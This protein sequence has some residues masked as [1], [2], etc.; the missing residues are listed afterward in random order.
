M[1]RIS[2]FVHCE[3]VPQPRAKVSTRGGFARAYV[4]AKHPINAY[5]QAIREAFQADKLSGPLGCSLLFKF[6][7]PKSHTKKQRQCGWHTGNSDIDNLAKAIFDALNGLAYDDD[8]QIAF[9]QAHKRWAYQGVDGKEDPG[10]TVTIW[11]L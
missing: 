11:E 1:K 6:S 3:P 2:F 10:V 7:R 9:V 8:K 5:K 4:D